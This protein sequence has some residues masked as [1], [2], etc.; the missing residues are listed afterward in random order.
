MLARSERTVRAYKPR[1]RPVK[2]A[3]VL[4]VVVALLAPGAAASALVIQRSLA[5][6]ELGMTQAQVRAH[7]GTPLRVV[8]SKNDFGPYTEFRYRHTTVG[9]QGDERVTD[10][11]STSTAERGPRGIGVGSTKAQVRAAVPGLKCEGPAPAGQC[12][13]GRYVPGGRVTAFFFQAGKVYELV[14]GYVID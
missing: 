11:I 9:F 10:V 5:G 7:L 3:A 4:L 2:R 12:Y 13:V 8:R 1:P 14:L 6:I